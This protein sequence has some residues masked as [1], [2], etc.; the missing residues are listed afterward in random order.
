M[1]MCPAKPAR[2]YIL[3]AEPRKIKPLDTHF[4]PK[5]RES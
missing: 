1:V 2:R 4:G 5:R 3:G